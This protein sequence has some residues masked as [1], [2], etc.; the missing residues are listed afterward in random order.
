MTAPNPFVSRRTLIGAGAGFVVAGAAASFPAGLARAAAPVSPAQ[1]AGVYR[2]AVGAFQVTALSDGYLD[3]PHGFWNGISAPEIKDAVTAAALPP[4]ESI[5][6]GVTSYLI[7]TGS[8][9]VLV[10]SGAAGLF[11]P[12]AKGFAGSLAAA[13][14]TPAQVDAIII[15]HMHPDHIGALIDNGAAVFPTASVHV[16]DVDFAYWTNEANKANVPDFAKQWFDVA[17]AVVA[18]YKPRLST[19]AAG[20]ELIPGISTSAVP[21]HTP[22]QSALRITSGNDSLMLVADA[23]GVAAVQFSHPDA[24]LAF[25]SDSKLAATTRRKLFDMVATDRT[26][27]AAAHLPFPTFGYVARSGGAYQYVPEEWQYL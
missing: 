27:I 8:K 4:R 12:T 22:G 6:L 11:G 19:F 20:T 14:V 1:V 2:R 17:K 25:D 9:L 23:V 5:R 21:G 3:V 24:G 10:D 18:A 7:N 16:S 15:T 26:L 13:G